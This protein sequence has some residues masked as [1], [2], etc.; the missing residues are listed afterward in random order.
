MQRPITSSMSL[1]IRHDGV[2]APALA[3][4]TDLSPCRNSYYSRQE[5][6]IPSPTTGKFVHV[7]ETAFLVDEIAEQLA[8]N[9]VEPVDHTS[10]LAS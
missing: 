8:W 3:L 9:L 2:F 7:L 5:A 6:Y 4:P 10:P 1:A